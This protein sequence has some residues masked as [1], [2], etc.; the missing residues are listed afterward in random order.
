MLTMH[1]KGSGHYLSVVPEEKGDIQKRSS[2]IMLTL[3]PIIYLYKYM[4]GLRV[5]ILL[6]KTDSLE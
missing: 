3:N 6:T 4:I 1:L 2:E 5:S